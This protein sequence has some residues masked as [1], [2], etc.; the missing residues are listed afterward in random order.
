MRH[1]CT[2]VTEAQSHP[3]HTRHTIQL[4]EWKHQFFES[5]NKTIYWGFH[6]WASIIHELLLSILTQLICS[7]V[8]CALPV[9][10]VCV[11]DWLYIVCAL[12]SSVYLHT[13]PTTK[14][15]YCQEVPKT[16]CHLYLYRQLS[17]FR[18]SFKSLCFSLPVIVGSYYPDL[19]TIL[20]QIKS[21]SR[22]NTLNAHVIEVE[23]TA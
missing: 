3:T 9:S 16:K 5:I 13:I 20:S 4:W 21:V 15:P 10:P 23:R 6:R 14:P 11:C 17:P 8:F 18:Q 12:C 7:L 2:R 22:C 19:C 1:I